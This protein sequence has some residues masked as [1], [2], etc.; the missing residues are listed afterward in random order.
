[1]KSHDTDMCLHIVHQY[2]SRCRSLD[3]VDKICFKNFMH[4]K[5]SFITSNHLLIYL[6]NKQLYHLNHMVNLTFLNQDF[7]VKQSSST[8]YSMKCH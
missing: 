6:G 2:N 8:R 7:V 3:A 5:L 4:Y 1:M